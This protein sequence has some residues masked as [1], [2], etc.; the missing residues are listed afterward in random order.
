MNQ[1]IKMIM[2]MENSNY[3]LFCLTDIVKMFIVNDRK[4]GLWNPI[5]LFFSLY[6]HILGIIYSALRGF[7]IIKKYHNQYHTCLILIFSSFSKSKVMTIAPVTPT[8][9]LN[10]TTCSLSELRFFFLLPRQSNPDQ[11]GTNSRLD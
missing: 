2:N 10:M 5:P 3:P 9:S 8:P 11:Q 7:H 6:M 1:F 4:I